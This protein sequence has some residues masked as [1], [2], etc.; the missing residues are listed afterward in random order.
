LGIEIYAIYYTGDKRYYGIN[1]RA[2]W[3]HP[4]SQTDIDAMLAMSSHS[5]TFV[6]DQPDYNARMG[7]ILTHGGAYS[8]KFFKSIDG[9]FKAVVAYAFDRNHVLQ[10]YEVEIVQ[11]P[12][13]DARYE[14][15]WN[16]LW[17]SAP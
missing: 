15:T 8:C 9:N 7:N 6:L 4:F 12:R 10:P 5:A 13:F 16:V 2:D 11:R 17:F 14:R 3:S 1:Y